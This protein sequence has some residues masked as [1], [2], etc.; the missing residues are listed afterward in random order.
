MKRHS[1]HLYLDTYQSHLAPNLKQ[2]GEG[3]VSFSLRG[4]L[5]CSCVCASLQT[6]P[7]GSSVF[8]QRDPERRHRCIRSS[9]I[10][11]WL[12]KTQFPPSTAKHRNKL[13]RSGEGEYRQS[14]SHS[15]TLQ[16]QYKAENTNRPQVSQFNKT[17]LEM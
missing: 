8:T 13:F 15:Q 5:S 16:L 17:S 2:G 12:Q 9:F 10:A 3:G 1:I 4:G 11:F 7:S 6:T 14:L